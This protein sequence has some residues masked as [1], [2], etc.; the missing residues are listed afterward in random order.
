MRKTLIMNEYTREVSFSSNS[1]GKPI[2]IACKYSRIN[3]FKG[4]PR[5]RRSNL[6]LD[7][8]DTLSTQQVSSLFQTGE[9][10]IR[11]HVRSGKLPSVRGSTHILRTHP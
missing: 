4:T 9:K 10:T 5:H 7:D 3:R 6:I 2:I 8:Y 11:K 1:E